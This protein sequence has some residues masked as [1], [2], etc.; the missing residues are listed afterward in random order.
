MT[1]FTDLMKIWKQILEMTN[2]ALRAQW[3]GKVYLSPR[4]KLDT[5]LNKSKRTIFVNNFVR[6]F[7]TN[8]M[9]WKIDLLD[10][11][12]IF[13]NKPPGLTA[14]SKQVLIKMF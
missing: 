7:D 2:L 10:T 11:L 14:S 12:F 1:Q 4:L 9:L 3:S 8:F 13:F 6:N 5:N